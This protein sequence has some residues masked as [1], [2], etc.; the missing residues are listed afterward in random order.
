M[1]C[2]CSFNFVNTLIAFILLLTLGPMADAEKREIVV[3]T[4]LTGSAQGTTLPGLP[5]GLCNRSLPEGGAYLIAQPVMPI[6]S[7]KLRFLAA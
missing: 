1:I 7:P 2:T 3:E 4:D 5:A 6:F